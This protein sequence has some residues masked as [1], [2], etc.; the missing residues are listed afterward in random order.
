MRQDAQENR[1]RILAAAEEVFGAHGAAGSTEEVARQAGV[2]IATVFRHFPAKEDLVEAALLRHFDGLA[3]RV[4]SL[5]AGPDPAAAWDTLVRTMI[6]TG[7][8]KL[9]LA[10]ALPGS[11]GF[12]DRAVAAS[13]RVKTAVGEV[14][15]QAQEHGAVRSSATIEEVYLLIRALSQASATMQIRRDTLDR[16]VDVVLAGLSQPAG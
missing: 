16:A 2:G 6:G 11:G 3:A 7:A 1:E 10:S 14:L 4:R 9:T 8:T 12:P 13:N 5:A 15:R